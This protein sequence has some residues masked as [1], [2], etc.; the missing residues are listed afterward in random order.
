MVIFLV[1]FFSLC[2]FRQQKS[3]D[4]Q[5]DRQT[6]R[7]RD[8]DRLQL[9]ITPRHKE[10]SKHRKREIRIKK[11]KGIKRR[12]C[13]NCKQRQQN[14]QQ[15]Q[16]H[17]STSDIPRFKIHLGM[18]PGYGR[19]TPERMWSRWQ[20]CKMYLRCACTVQTG[21]EAGPW[22]RWPEKNAKHKHVNPLTT[23]W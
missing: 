20:R 10:T 3:G 8:T 9:S 5:T 7:D 6:D 14:R 1:F 23:E 11:L 2:F 4:R 22:A 18:K 13:K 15:T 21:P 19:E 17:V 16:T 12:K